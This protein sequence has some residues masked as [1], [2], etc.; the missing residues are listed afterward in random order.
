MDTRTP[1][2]PY[3]LFVG[4][5]RLKA[6]PGPAFLWNKGRGIF[7]VALVV[8]EE[9]PPPIATTLPTGDHVT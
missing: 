9:H 5:A 1:T 3:S 4:R 6:G 2:H 7:K 8:A